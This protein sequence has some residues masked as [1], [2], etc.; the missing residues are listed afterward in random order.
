MRHRA[1]AAAA[2]DDAYMP[3]P[4]SGVNTLEAIS[5]DFIQVL[6][7]ARYFG[8]EPYP[9]RSRAAGPGVFFG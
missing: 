5:F 3:A 9:T 4:G 6:D 8:P 7:P 1:E 2:R